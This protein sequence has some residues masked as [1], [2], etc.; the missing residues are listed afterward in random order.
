V[1]VEELDES[2]ESGRGGY[3]EGQCGFEFGSFLMQGAPPFLCGCTAFF[4][5]PG[6]EFLGDLGHRS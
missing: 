6:L 2:D 3:F 4:F 5:L 1:L